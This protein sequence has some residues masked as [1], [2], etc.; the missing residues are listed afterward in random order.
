MDNII[1]Q[2]VWNVN[3]CVFCENRRILVW[4]GYEKCVHFY[5]LNE[6]KA[7]FWSQ[8]RPSKYGKHISGTNYRSHTSSPEY[9]WKS[10]YILL[11][12]PCSTVNIRYQTSVHRKSAQHKFN[13]FRSALL[14]SSICKLFIHCYSASS[15]LAM[16]RLVIFILAYERATDSVCL[17][18]HCGGR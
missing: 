18:N 7:M 8:P 5:Y 9:Y 16:R 17:W 11:N 3:Y 12:T 10:Q 6:V 2:F 14:F 4:N 13:I 15:V 1:W